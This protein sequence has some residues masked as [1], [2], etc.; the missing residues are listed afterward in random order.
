MM[1]TIY[2]VWFLGWVLF[3]YRYKALMFC[4]ICIPLMEK[5]QVVEGGDFPQ[6]ALF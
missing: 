4:M 6:W 3:G 1:T 2:C 5:V